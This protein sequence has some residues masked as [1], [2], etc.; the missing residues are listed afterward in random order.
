MTPFAF[1]INL[2]KQIRKLPKILK[3]VRIIIIIHYYSKLFTGVLKVDVAEAAQRLLMTSSRQRT[4]NHRD[5]LAI[6]APPGTQP[7]RPPSTSPGARLASHASAIVRTFAWILPGISS[8]LA[9]STG[10]LLTSQKEFWFYQYLKA[11]R[12]G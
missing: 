4:P 10:K 2:R 9:G 12:R 6:D 7:E 11:G 5:R 8:R 1:S 3:F